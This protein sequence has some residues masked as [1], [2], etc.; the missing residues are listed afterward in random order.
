MGIKKYILYTKMS[1]NNDLCQYL[2]NHL[3]GVQATL[4]RLATDG[5]QLDTSGAMQNPT[6]QN[7]SN[8]N[9]GVSFF[10]LIVVAYLLM[11]LFSTG[12]RMA[13]NKP[14]N[15]LPQNI[16]DQRDGM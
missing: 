7:P 3:S 4:T 2:F 10:I 5:T 11:T 6:Q 16:E 1:N 14:Q 9:L 13:S 8:S 12:S 15:T